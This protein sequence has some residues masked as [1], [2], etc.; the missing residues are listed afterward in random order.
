[1]TDARATKALIILDGF[2]VEVTP[3]SAVEA[4]HTP[5][6]DRLL[7]DNP[8]SRIET[9]G[10]AVGLPDGQMGNSEVGHMN[11]GA[12]RT[13]YQNFTRISKSIADGDFFDNAALCE[14]MDKAI[15][16]GRAVHVMGLL[17][18][19]GVHSHEEHI[20]ALLEMAVKRGAKS[21]YLHAI[22]DGRDMPPRS[23]EPSL[24]AAQATFERLGTGAIATV[25]GRYYAMDRDNRW[26]R[27]EQAYDAMTRGQA[28]VTAESALQALEA[29]YARDENDEFV[30]ATV[31]TGADGQPVATVEAGDALICANFRPDRAREITRCFVEPEFDGFARKA[32]PALSGYVMMTEYAADIPAPVAFPPEQIHNDLGEY[33]AAQGKT[34]LRIAETEKYAHVTFFFNGGQ[35]AVYPGE[36]RILVPSPQVATYDLQPE[37]SAPE[38]T[39]KLC[40]AIRSGKYDLIVC[41]YANGDMVGHTGNFDAA[42]K[43]VETVDQ[44]LTQVLAALAD[45]GGEALITADHGNV[46]MMQ[47]PN[48][49]QPHT[50]H[51]NWPVALIYA[52]PRAERVTLSDGAL[53]DLAPTLL[54]LMELSAPTEMTGRSLV[55]LA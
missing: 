42:V 21:V 45:V 3:S 15:E 5:T 26:E 39:E 55:S 34:Q 49:G 38:V 16:A 30:K 51:T 19:G 43:A 36:D 52:G 54:D 33:L 14:A 18:P 37:M 24:K 27:V 4:A 13:V 31:I 9:S 1:M 29:A 28:E 40:E 32:H 25:V 11:I 48:T 2:G 41:N 23:A 44:S 47:D 35:E 12:G 22:L 20:F 10:M 8:N 7:A 6:W 50:A 17:S 46:E 53:C